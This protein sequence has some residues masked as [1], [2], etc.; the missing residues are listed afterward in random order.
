METSW[1][2][3]FIVLVIF[4]AIA[5]YLINDQAGVCVM[6]RAFFT[7]F[8]VVVALWLAWLFSLMAEW[9][10]RTGDSSVVCTA[11]WMILFAGALFL[12]FV[13]VALLIPRQCL[14]W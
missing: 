7:G 1:M 13:I 3:F 9:V 4:L 11:V 5:V 2:V 6:A 8:V 14:Q 10:W 12:V